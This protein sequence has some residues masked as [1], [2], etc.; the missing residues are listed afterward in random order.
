MNEQMRALV[1][2][3]PAPNAQPA[4]ISVATPT[5]GPRAV[6]IRVAAA[7]LNPIDIKITTG[8]VGLRRTPNTLGFDVAG[9][10]DAVG[11]DVSDYHPGDRVFALTLSAGS[12]ADF[13][14]V[15]VGP[16]LARV[17]DDLPMDVAAALPSAGA[18][19]ATLI[20]AARIQ[21][22]ERVLVNG[23]AGGLGTFAVQ[24]A[25]QAGAR[26]LATGRAEDFPL[27]DRLGAT[28]TIDY[29]TGQSLGDTVSMLADDGVDVLVDLVRA[30]TELEAMSAVVV[31]GGRVVS[32]LGGP[33]SLPR[34]I[35]VAYPPIHPLAPGVLGDLASAAASGDI[36]VVT[37]VRGTLADSEAILS[38]FRTEHRRGKWIITG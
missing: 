7:A 28:Q 3:V 10:I 30:G 4:L 17:P 21:A 14:V 16:Y 9:T 36:T 2:D 35:N 11:D 19:A 23:A 27:L 5:P 38:A 26:V 18:S 1:V 34:G 31:D 6:R 33:G 12:L 22:G 24:F 20:K 15:D 37:Q 13:V 25:A 8:E 29:R 32:P